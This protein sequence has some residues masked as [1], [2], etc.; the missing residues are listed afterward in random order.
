MLGGGGGG[1]CGS[2]DLTS[3]ECGSVGDGEE[4]KMLHKKAPQLTKMIPQPVTNIRLEQRI[5]QLA[6][7]V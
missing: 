4:I 1:R 7:L 5:E 2:F 3:T 6:P